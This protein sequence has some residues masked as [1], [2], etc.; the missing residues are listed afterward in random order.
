M[1]CRV[2]LTETLTLLLHA[3]LLEFAAELPPLESE[4]CRFHW[5]RLGLAQLR[6][7]VAQLPVQ[8][9]AQRLNS[10]IRATQ[11]SI[12]NINKYAPTIKPTTQVRARGTHR[13]VKRRGL[14]PIWPQRLLRNNTLGGTY[15]A[16]IETA[17]VVCATIRVCKRPLHVLDATRLHN[18]R[19]W[20]IHLV[21]TER[22]RKPQ[23]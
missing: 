17:T 10:W 14:W 15:S 18:L 13:G 3:F 20:L 1:L 16:V 12:W 11:S 19:A 9:R 8:L 5:R 6:K 4:Q 22:T 23:S 2:K 21:V 7:P